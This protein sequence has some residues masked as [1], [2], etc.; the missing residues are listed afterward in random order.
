MDLTK[1]LPIALD[2][3]Q[4]LGGLTILATILVRF[5]ANDKIKS[6]VGEL[7]GGWLKVVQFLPTLGINPQTKA[8]EAALSDAMAKNQPLPPSVPPAQ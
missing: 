6:I 2:V 8:L 5:I 4:A 3:L 1:I 7:D